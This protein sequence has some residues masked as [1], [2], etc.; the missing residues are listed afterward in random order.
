[1]KPLKAL[2]VYP[3]RIIGVSTPYDAAFVGFI[4][5]CVPMKMWDKQTSTW[6]IPEMYL[7]LV[8]EAGVKSRV[9]SQAEVDRFLKEQKTALPSLKDDN[10]LAEAARFLGVLPD[11][12]LRLVELAYGYWLK[13][14]SSAGGAG[15]RLAVLQEAYEVMKLR[16]E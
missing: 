8:A 14:F 3:T 1:M 9:I 5:E 7:S 10:A 6:W 15:D 11:A 12:P 2:R 4:K 16:G 13:E